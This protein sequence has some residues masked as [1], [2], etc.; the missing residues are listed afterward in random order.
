MQAD[1]TRPRCQEI[2]RLLLI[3]TFLES[4]GRLETLA[5]MVLAA[6]VSTRLL[7]VENARTARRQLR[8]MFPLEPLDRWQLLEWDKHGPT[9]LQPVLARMKQ[10]DSVG[11][12]AEAGCPGVADPGQKLVAAAHAAGYPVQPLVGPSSIL[13][14]LM[15]SGFSGQSFHFHGYLPREGEAL[16]L[17]LLELERAAALSTQIWIETPYRNQGLLLVLLRHLAPTTM[18]CIACALLEG[19]GWVRRQTLR[20][21]AAELP[22]LEGR[23]TVFLLGSDQAEGAQLKE[24]KRKDR[25]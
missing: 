8:R 21:W 15:A 6:L 18:L 1:Q 5:P 3:P 13:L 2:G 24:R 25:G 4:E 20:A 17:K 11:L 12:L 9:D 19:D 10:G 22:A 23:P 16:R 14:A 7:V